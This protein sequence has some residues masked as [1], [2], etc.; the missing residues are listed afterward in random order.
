M[1]MGKLYFL[2]SFRL[3]YRYFLDSIRLFS[4]LYLTCCESIGTGLDCLTY[5]PYSNSWPVNQRKSHINRFTVPKER[6]QTQ[7]DQ[8]STTIKFSS[9]I[10]SL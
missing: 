7:L 2:F 4:D 9:N 10:Y 5:L 6:Q 8:P 1:W 3:F